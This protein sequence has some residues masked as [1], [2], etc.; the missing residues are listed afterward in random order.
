MSDIIFNIFVWIREDYRGWPFRFYCEVLAWFGSI[1]TALIMT[2]TLPDPPLL[3]LYIAWVISTSIY[4]WAAWSR[5]SFGML[6]NYLLLFVID[7]I[8]LVKLVFAALA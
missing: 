5:G 1:G 6:A 3:P 8:G 7:I 4:A 2:L